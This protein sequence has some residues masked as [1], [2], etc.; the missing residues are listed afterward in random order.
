MSLMS[1]IH[2]SNLIP[3]NVSMLVAM[4]AEN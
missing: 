4:K 1:V 3:S 2:L